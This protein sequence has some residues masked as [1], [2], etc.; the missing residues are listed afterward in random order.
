MDEEIARRS[1]FLSIDVLPPKSRAQALA[2]LRNGKVLIGHDL[3]SNS[4][5]TTEIPGG[6]IHDWTGV[7]FIPGVSIAKVISTLQDYDQAA[8][9]Y[10][11]QVIKSKLLDHSGDD[12]RVY[13][14]LKQVHVITVV[15]DTD[16]QVHYT[17]L[18]SAHVAARS[19]SVRIAEVRNVGEPREREM[20]PGDDDG[21]LW[22]LDSYWRFY[23]TESG[24]YVQ[25]N[26]IS[27][28]R[29][30]PVGLGWL[31]RRFLETI[32]R[33]SLRL[34][35]ES[36]RNAVLNQSNEQPPRDPSGTGDGLNE[37]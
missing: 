3:T 9:Y 32:P 5:D 7:V 19:Y 35:L 26:A 12:F 10:K 23:Q 36:T 24:V 29:D 8:L 15:L 21:F 20:P 28:T 4:A 1:H 14:R 13:L 6:L 18:D 30:V 27:L 22:R 2:D 11:P 33:D 16:Y 37:H 25:C 34:T 17:F 31:V